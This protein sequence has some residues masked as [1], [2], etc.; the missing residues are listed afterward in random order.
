MLFENKVVAVLLAGGSGTRMGYDI[1][2]QLLKLSGSTILEHTLRVFEEDPAI[3]EIIIVSRESEIELLSKILK[4]NNSKISKIISGGLTRDEST[5][6]ALAEIEGNP[7]LLI[8]DAVRPFIS[9]RI[10]RDCIEALES[11][12]AVDTAISSADTIIEVSE[13]N[14]IVGIPPRDHLR[15]GQ[16]PQAFN[17]EVLRQA[18][19]LAIK[20]KSFQPTD[21]CGVIHRYLPNEPIFVIEGSAENIKVTEPIDIHIAE[22]I[23]QLK[24]VEQTNSLSSLDVLKSKVIV[25]FGGSYGI[26]KS[27]KILAEEYGS[28]VYSFSRSVTDTNILDMTSVASALN[29]VLNKE[30]RIDSVVITAAILKIKKLSELSES[31]I[32][33][34]ILTNLAAPALI[35]H[36]V[37]PYLKESKGNLTFFT[38]SSYTRGRSGYAL[39]SATKAGIVNLT[40]ALSEEWQS[41]DIRVNAINPQRTNTPMR[42]NSFGDEPEETLLTSESVAKAT[43]LSISS[44]VSGQTIDVK[45]QKS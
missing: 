45:L 10:I 12:N 44:D 24:S 33:E 8:H 4:S 32:N 25:I 20:D 21:D 3:D 6:K 27:I 11:F 40:Q 1:P 26:G 2:K 5:R 36:Q 19:A 31:E 43:L 28:S 41:S 17:A 34:V 23:F 39:Y 9:T 22:K 15:R 14:T 35:A 37:Y 42:V 16:T 7:K 38:S 30:G 13:L 29:D 18:H